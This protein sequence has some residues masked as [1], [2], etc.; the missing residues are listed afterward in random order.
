MIKAN[1]YFPKFSLLR[2]IFRLLLR[3]SFVH[4]NL[5]SCGFNFCVLLYFMPSSS[6][7][8]SFTRA[9]T[10]LLTVNSQSRW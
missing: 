5:F 1:G 6:A 9:S 4:A 3:K 8:M 10:R 2:C 7:Q